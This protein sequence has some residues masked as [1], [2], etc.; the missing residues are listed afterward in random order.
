MMLK[1]ISYIMVLTL[2]MGCILS[3]EVLAKFSTLFYIIFI[4]GLIFTVKNNN[5]TIEILAISS[6]FLFGSWSY[7]KLY[8]KILN[9]ILKLETKF[10]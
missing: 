4:F 8:K 10:I 5:V 1:K 7:C 3:Y 6:L 2:K 9:W